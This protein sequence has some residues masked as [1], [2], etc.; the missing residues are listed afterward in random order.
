MENGLPSYVLKCILFRIVEETSAENWMASSSITVVFN[1]LLDALCDG[2]RE[3]VYPHYW[4]DSINLLED[5]DEISMR[6]LQYRAERVRY[7]PQAYVADNWLELTRCLRHNCCLCCPGGSGKVAK[8]AVSQ[9]RK[10]CCPCCLI[11]V[12]Y[13]ERPT[14]CGPCPIDRLTMDVY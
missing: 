5:I 12:S 1:R 9:A 10:R 14:C 11:P 8:R 3:R 6:T 13:K 4:I 2:L 7:K